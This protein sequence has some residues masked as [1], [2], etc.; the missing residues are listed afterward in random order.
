MA[1]Q[2]WPRG[3]RLSRSVLV[4]RGQ[5]GRVHCKGSRR[6]AGSAMRRPWLVGRTSVLRLL[7]RMLRRRG[8][9]V[10]R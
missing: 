3:G 5:P 4:P 2:R 1:V 7:P 8:H 6:H 9:Y 10:Q